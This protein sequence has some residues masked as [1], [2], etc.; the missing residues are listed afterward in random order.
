MTPPGPLPG[1]NPAYAETAPSETSAQEDRDLV[2]R[3]I[4]D[5]LMFGASRDDLEEDARLLS[6]GYIDSLSCLRLV[7]F[8]EEQFQVTIPPG[9]LNAEHFN[10]IEAIIQCVQA[11]RLLTRARAL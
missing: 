3:F 2:E 8:L 7:H 5:Q 1:M 6:D 4:L 10:T 11:N 9:H